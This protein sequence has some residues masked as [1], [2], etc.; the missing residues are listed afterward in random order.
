MLGRDK[1]E[2]M[3]RTFEAKE[4]W[5]ALRAE[6]ATR[7]PEA[8]LAKVDEAVAFAVHRHADQK[9]PAGE[10]YLE[11]LLE[12]TRVLVE[13]VGTTDIDVL[14]AAV[15]HDVVEDT[16]CTLDEVRDQFGDRVA[17]LVDWLTKPE[18]REGESREEARTAYLERLSNAPDE[19]VVLVKLAD[20]LSNVQRLDTHPR[21]AKRRVY[22]A[23]TVELILPL[24]AR[25]PWY[26]QWYDEWRAEFSGL[27]DE[28][29]AE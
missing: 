5:P 24:A 19:A 8:D 27:A 17:G 23:E 6:W 15:L 3:M 21:P 13:G 7:L 26:R 20:R 2:V 29:G 14:R 11:H 4:G 16:P 10:P 12:A 28:S 25:H 1:G 9:R 22:Y 18:R